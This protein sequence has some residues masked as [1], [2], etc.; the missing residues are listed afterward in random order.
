MYNRDAFRS[1]FVLTLYT[2]LYEKIATVQYKDV[3]YVVTYS[4]KYSYSIHLKFVFLAL[5]IG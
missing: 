5:Y 3:L 2:P 4:K 1:A